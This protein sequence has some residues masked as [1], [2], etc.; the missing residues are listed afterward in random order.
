MRVKDD[1]IVTVYKF[2]NQGFYPNIEGGFDMYIDM[3]TEVAFCEALQQ[4]YVSIEAV[5]YLK[6]QY[7][8]D[9]L[10]V[11]SEEMLYKDYVQM[12]KDKLNAKFPD[13]PVLATIELD[14]AG[15]PKPE[16][17]DHLKPTDNFAKLRT[18]G[19]NFTIQR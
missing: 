12:Y 5:K 11:E 10:K 4:L 7:V 13:A 19:L 6:S 9:I 17:P 1:M 16:L 18:A 3:Y 8:A 14:A 15:R 2:P